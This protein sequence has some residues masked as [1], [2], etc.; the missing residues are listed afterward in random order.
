MATGKEFRNAGMGREERRQEC[1]D[2]KY[3]RGLVT[4]NN[5]LNNMT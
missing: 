3:D 5:L 1:C 2:E 4:N